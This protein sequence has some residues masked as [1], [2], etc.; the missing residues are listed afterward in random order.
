[1][2][3]EGLA[4]SLKAAD[5]SVH[6]LATVPL[7]DPLSAAAELRHAVLSLGFHGAMI[8]TNVERR[9]LGDAALDPFWREAMDLGVPVILHPYVLEDVARFKEYYLHNLVGYPFETTLA[10]CSLIFG[11]TLDRMPELTVVLVHG[12]GFFP[13]QVERFDHGHRARPEPGSRTGKPVHAPLLLRHPHALTPITLL[14]LRHR[15]GRPAAARERPPDWPRPSGAGARAPG[16]QAWGC[17]R[18]RRPGKQRREALPAGDVTATPRSIARHG[19]HMTS[20][21]RRSMPYDSPFSG[22]NKMKS[23]GNYSG[24]HHL[25]ATNKMILYPLPHKSIEKKFF[26][27]NSD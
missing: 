4:E 2:L 16:R 1:M 11:G 22:R 12:G 24:R 14:S 13:Y 27:L 10:A 21:D 18:D 15:R 26:L 20:P 17:R 25:D 23:L 5:L 6:G 8:D 19:G 3:N 7:Q 9:P